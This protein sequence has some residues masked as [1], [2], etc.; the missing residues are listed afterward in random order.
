MTGK[1][2]YILRK[3][4]GM[5]QKKFGDLLGVHY[6]TVGRWE[7]ERLKPQGAALKGLVELRKRCTWY[8]SEYQGKVFFP[9]EGSKDND[10]TWFPPGSMRC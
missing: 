6:V 4:Y 5:T 3:C 10:G 9:S 1:E 7:N 2:I 8:D